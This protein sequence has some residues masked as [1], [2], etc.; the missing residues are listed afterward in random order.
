[1]RY[2]LPYMGSKSK[3]ARQIVDFLPAGQMLVDLFAGGGAITHAALLSGKWERVIANDTSD[4]IQLFYDA[5]KGKYRNEKRWISRED[6]WRLK[7]TDPYVKYCW[8]FGNGGYSYLYGKHVEEYK[9]HLHNVYTAETLAECK[10]EVRKLLRYL[11]DV[12]RDELDGESLQRLQ[13]LERLDSLESLESL[14]R[15]SVSRLDYAQ[16]EI[17]SGA[18]VYCD[19][20]YN[21]S[22]STIQKGTYC[23]G[24]D[25][26][27]FYAWAQS[28]DFPVYISE[29]TMPGGF[30][31]VW[32]MEKQNTFG[33]GEKQK[34]MT[35]NIF[36]A[37]KFLEQVNCG[38]HHLME[39]LTM[40]DTA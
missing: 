10:A 30:T 40:F 14:E 33:G 37:D 27:R 3:I 21:T 31:S 6:W 15:L 38:E 2:G 25:F 1:M 11:S 20:P 16:V 35:E 13:S 7:D 22:A 4:I 39:Q 17:P 36:V 34:T 26:D 18:V 5:A 12:R 9:H 8:S 19:I 24:F 32:H 28:R 23:N 29:Y